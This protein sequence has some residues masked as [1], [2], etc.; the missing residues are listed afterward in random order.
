MS[1]SAQ[2]LA[3]DAA[4][5]RIRDK[6]LPRYP[7]KLN[8]TMYH[9]L[10]DTTAK[11]LAQFSTVF[12]DHQGR[13]FIGDVLSDTEF[14]ALTNQ[15]IAYVQPD[16]DEDQYDPDIDD[17]MLE[18]ARKQAE[19]QW[20]DRLICIATRRGALRGVKE[21]FM[22]AVDE[23]YYEELEDRYDGYKNVSIK[24]F[25]HHLNS[26]WCVLG[27]DA[28]D[29]EKKHYYRDVTFD[30]NNTVAKF[31]KTLNNEQANLERD[32][33]NI[34]EADK[35]HHFL[36]QVRKSRKFSN[37]EWKTYNKK[38][39]AQRTWNL[40]AAHF[41]ELE[42]EDET[43]DAD[44]AIGSIRG[45]GYESA[46]HVEEAARAIQ[47]EQQ[48]KT[49]AQN[50]Q[51]LNLLMQNR[52]EKAA[53][54]SFKLPAPAPAPA[55]P[56]ATPV[57]EKTANAVDN[58]QMMDMMMTMMREMNTL[59]QQVNDR[60]NVNPN[61]VNTILGPPCKHCGKQHPHMPDHKL[62]TEAECPGRDWP[63]HI[64]GSNAAN[65]RYFINRM[66]KRT[67]ITYVKDQE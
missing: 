67:G 57:V 6:P 58:K 44:E 59:K 25:F 15:N 34:S 13:G 26:V 49:I 19:A 16:D 3:E 12:E 29:S 8:R 61:N 20:D 51:I 42:I 1:R 31:V 35:Q 18:S 10:R 62:G 45:G 66:N 33:I 37:H 52:A 27:L 48:E 17:T 53:A 43:F 14:R 55:K 11:Q 36:M 24:D 65:D 21:N 4:Y 2:K 46:N 22:D 64:K 7:G 5:K 39:A 28:V 63:K 56:A 9:D 54:V 60:E 50:E 32:D 41:K 23:K 30:K 47:W 40:T 38:P